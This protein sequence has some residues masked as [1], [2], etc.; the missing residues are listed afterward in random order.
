MLNDSLYSSESIEWETPKDLFD[1]LH[2]EFNF[3]LDVCANSAN[4][5]CWKYFTIEQ[6]SLL[7]EWNGVC[8]MNPPYGREIY[9]WVQ[10]AFNESQK[11]STIVCL[12]PTR[13]DTQWWHSYCMKSFEIRLLTRR[14]T[15]SKYGNKAPFPCAIV[16]FKLGNHKPTLS[17]MKS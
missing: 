10:K 12:L 17:A 13:T 4:A 3:T 2:K 8:Y 7:L 14:L 6:N 16:I 15:F 5:K 9:W 1:D 11:G